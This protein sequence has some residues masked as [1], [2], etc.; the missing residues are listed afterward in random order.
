MFLFHLSAVIKGKNNRNIKLDEGDTMQGVDE[1]GPTSQ[2]IS[3]FCKQ[4]GDLYVM[5]PIGTDVKGG[6]DMIDVLRQELKKTEF[7]QPQRGDKVIYKGRK[8]TIK[9]YYSR[10]KDELDTADLSF[11]GGEEEELKIERKDFKVIEVAIKLFDQQ[12][13]GFVLQRDDFFR[14]TYDKVTSYLPLYE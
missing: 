3:E 9:K 12:S 2:F 13:S 8:A 11:N 1:G 5:L 10:H 4:L 6:Q 14:N 7:L